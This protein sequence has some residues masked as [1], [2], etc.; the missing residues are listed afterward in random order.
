[1]GHVYSKNC[2]DHPDDMFFGDL[3]L[4]AI[5]RNDPENVRLGKNYNEVKFNEPRCLRSLAER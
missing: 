4:A 1:M 5:A 2:F 3:G